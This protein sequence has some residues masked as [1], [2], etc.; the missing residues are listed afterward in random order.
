MKR[1]VT[2]TSPL[3]KV[4]TYILG[5]LALVTAPL[6]TGGTAPRPAS[7]P[8][9]ATATLT[10][11]QHSMAR[12]QC[13]KTY[14]NVSVA[15]SRGAAVLFGAPGIE[16][17]GVNLGVLHMQAE[18]CANGTSAWITSNG[19]QPQCWTDDKI[20]GTT[21]VWGCSVQPWGSGIQLSAEMKTVAMPA[22]VFPVNL[23]TFDWLKFP[24]PASAAGE[25]G[26]VAYSTTWWA[27]TYLDCNNNFCPIVG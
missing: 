15:M 16:L 2:A 21:Q 4:S 11:Y 14:H 7:Q 18:V 1:S 8:H 20:T 23:E 19:G 12:T 5:V 27:Q 3:L 6:L 10:A 9:G 13:W 25:T 17:S 24:I 26:A 22:Y